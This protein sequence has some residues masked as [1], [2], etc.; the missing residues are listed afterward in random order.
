VSRT[1]GVEIVNGAID[2][3]LVFFLNAAFRNR[4]KTMGD[5]SSGSKPTS[6]TVEAASRSA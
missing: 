1:T 6:N 2:T 3:T 4:R 5:S